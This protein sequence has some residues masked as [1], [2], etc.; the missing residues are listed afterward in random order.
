MQ[1][2]AAGLLVA[3]P[4]NIDPQRL[5]ARTGRVERKDVQPTTIAFHHF[6]KHGSG[7]KEISKEVLVSPL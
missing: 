6:P 7:R 5:A 4:G 1:Y 2:N 3:E